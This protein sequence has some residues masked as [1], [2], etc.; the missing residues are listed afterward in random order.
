MKW[1]KYS[2]RRD[3]TEF[4]ELYRSWGRHTGEAAITNN[5]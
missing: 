4:A 1:G 3:L 2:N 5:N